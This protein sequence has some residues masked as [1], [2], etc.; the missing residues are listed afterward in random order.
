V[1]DLVAK[2]K[3]EILA[4]TFRVGIDESAPKSE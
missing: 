3:A 4:G 1:K 2:R